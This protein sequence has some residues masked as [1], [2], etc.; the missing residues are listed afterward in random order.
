MNFYYRLKQLSAEKKENEDDTGYLYDFHEKARDILG[1]Y[2][3]TIRGRCAVCLENF[4]KE[5]KAENDVKFTERID[6]TRMND[7]YHKFHLIC[8]HRD[9]FMQ[10]F[11]EK[12]EYGGDI[13]YTIPDVK[14]CPICRREVI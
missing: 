1:I 2:N 4:A 10:R 11:T 3:D 14:K 9:W 5:E 6:L 12:D 13:N 7:C 8:V